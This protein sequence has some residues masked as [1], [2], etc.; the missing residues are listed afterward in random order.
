MDDERDFEEQQQ[1]R[2]KMVLLAATITFIFWM[3][4]Q[5]I[6]DPQFNRSVW[7]LMHPQS[8]IPVVWDSSTYPFHTSSFTDNNSNAAEPIVGDTEERGKE[9]QHAGLVHQWLGNDHDQL[10]IVFAK[11]NTETARR[12]TMSHPAMVGGDEANVDATSLND[13][14]RTGTGESG[15]TSLPVQVMTDQHV[16]FVNI[17]GSYRGVC[18]CVCVCVGVGVGVG[19]GVLCFFFLLSLQSCY[20]QS[21]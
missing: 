7:H 14:T 15:T 12:Y 19:V 2:S 5:P 13:T 11:L 21:S 1:L 3:S 20:K 10:K 18:V 16:P 6:E 17:S 8:S 9:Q 4:A